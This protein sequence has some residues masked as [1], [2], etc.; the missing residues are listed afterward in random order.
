MKEDSGVREACPA[1]EPLLSSYAA[2]A[3]DEES[4]RRV[5]DHLAVCDACRA[6]QVERDPSVLFLE[7][8]RAP[9]PGGFLDGLAAGVRRRLESESRPGIPVIRWI[10]APGARR[11]AYV[12]APL[13][14]LLLF[15]TILLVRPG[16]PLRRGFRE[17]GQ[18][19]VTLPYGG[20]GVIAR[21]PRPGAQPQGPPSLQPAAPFAGPAGAPPL[22]EEVG[23]PSA[24]VYRFTVENGADETPIYFVVDE[25][26]D[27]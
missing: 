12:A 26:I 17:R 8:R 27:I 16:R 20:V 6:D 2:G 14:T 18:G 22:M 25:S 11:L 4:E 21:P 24:R 13:M 3:L 23:S 10:A 9:L 5:R 7:L 1:V 19:V 15:G